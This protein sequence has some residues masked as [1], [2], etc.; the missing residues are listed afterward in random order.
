MQ[1][2]KMAIVCALLLLVVGLALLKVY[3]DAARLSALVGFSRAGKTADFVRRPGISCVESYFYFE[4]ELKDDVIFGVDQ[5]FIEGSKAP[6]YVK[7]GDWMAFVG[8]QRTG[9]VWV[10]TGTE[11]TM[12]G[13]PSQTRKWEILNLGS[14]LRPDTWYR[15][16]CRADFGTRHFV[17]MQV[18]GPGLSKTLDLSRYKLDY[19]NFMPFDGAAMTYYV[20]AMRG[21]SMMK[22]EGKPLVYFDDLQG[23]LA[24][25]GENSFSQVFFNDCETQQKVFK[26]PVSGPPIKLENY[27]D[28]LL[29][30]ERDEAKAELI[31][32]SM[33]HSG[34]RVA[35]LNAGL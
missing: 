1:K 32:S 8:L 14:K 4:D 26:Q 16:R 6:L 3:A 12:S 27:K 30:F 18:E 21:R 25:K 19:P 10:A 28:G 34:R 24:P 15:I 13:K 35:R 23:S 11:A 31:E 20:H 22:E 9:T 17:D 5:E 2:S 7:G 29:Y 33:A